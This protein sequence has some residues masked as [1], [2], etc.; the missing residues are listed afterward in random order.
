[1]SP[2]LI[3]PRVRPASRACYTFLFQRILRLLPH[4]DEGSSACC[5]LASNSCSGTVLI[6][7]SFQP[8]RRAGGHFSYG[9]KCTSCPTP[10]PG[11]LS[12][13]STGGGVC[14]AVM[15]STLNETTFQDHSD[16]GL[17]SSREDV[18]GRC[19]IILSKWKI[20]G[21]QKMSHLHTV[22]SSLD[23]ASICGH[24]Q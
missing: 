18:S 1:M 19:T 10:V 4:K 23:N 12:I 15:Q 11:P 20:Y 2:L 16:Y 14:K 9:C 8:C 3:V 22:L 24:Y 7:V 13:L 21:V 5:R 6:R 17:K